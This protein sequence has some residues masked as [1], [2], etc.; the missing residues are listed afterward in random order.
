MKRKKINNPTKKTSNFN[1]PQ[2]VENKSYDQCKPYFSLTHI[3]KEHSIENCEKDEKAALIDT[4]YRLSQKTWSEIKTMPRHG[5]GFEKI[6]RTSIKA[7]IP[8]HITEDVIFIAFRFY[9]KA[10]IVGYR[11]KQVFNIVW[12]DREFNLYKH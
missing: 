10:P 2:T 12:I 8:N 4:L 1:I 6:S 5:L 3:Q 7:G 9:G 11:D